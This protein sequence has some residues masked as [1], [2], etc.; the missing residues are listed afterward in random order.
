MSQPHLSPDIWLRFF[1]LE[2][3]VSTV[4]KIGFSGASDTA[5]ADNEVLAAPNSIPNF[6]MLEVF[7]G[8]SLNK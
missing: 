6:L 4:T 8:F 2:K 3:F 1:F 5:E 7:T